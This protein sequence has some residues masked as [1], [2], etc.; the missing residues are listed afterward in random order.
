MADVSR[1]CKHCQAPFQSKTARALYCSRRCNKEYHRS[2]ERKLV[3]LPEHTQSQ[4]K[5]YNMTVLKKIT[6]NQLD[7][8][9]EMAR[10]LYLGRID[11][12]DYDYLA[13]A[14]SK[15]NFPRKH[16]RGALVQLTTSSLDA[17]LAVVLGNAAQGYRLSSVPTVV[18]G[19]AHTVYMLKPEAQVTAQLKEVRQEVEAALQIE[20]EKQNDKIIA[21]TVAQ[22]KAT[23]LR[24]RA[25]AAKAADDALEAG[26]LAEVRAA[27]GAK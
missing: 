20:I 19:S 10:Q 23:E 11:G 1:L 26:L 16:F 24:K 17:L 13:P 3:T 8:A 7:E 9:Y 14:D 6:Q 27:L 4:D 22:R 18:L 25:D 21:A 15:G 5:E 2:P 12:F